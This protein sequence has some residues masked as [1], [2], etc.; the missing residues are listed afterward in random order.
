MKCVWCLQD[1]AEVRRREFKGEE[2]LL[3]ACKACGATGPVHYISKGALPPRIKN[4]NV[5]IQALQ[6]EWLTV[7]MRDPIH[8]IACNEKFNDMIKTHIDVIKE[9]P[10]VM[11]SE[12]ADYLAKMD[13]ERFDV[14]KKNL[15]DLFLSLYKKKEDKDVN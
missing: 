8:I 6:N 4:D 12:D 15:R 7:S 3:V 14:H 1:A 5:N 9:D 11:L 2:Y 13:K 10:N